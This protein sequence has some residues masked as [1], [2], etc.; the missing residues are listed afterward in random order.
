M[1]IIYKMAVIILFLNLYKVISIILFVIFV[2]ML[3]YI[4]YIN[5][6]YNKKKIF[7]DSILAKLHRIDKNFKKDEII[8]F[9]HKLEKTNISSLISKDHIF[10]NDIIDYIFENENNLKIFL[11]Y[12]KERSVA[13]NILKEGFKFSDS[14]YKT[15]E[16][17]YPDKISFV[18]K[19]NLRKHFGNYVIIIA[20]SKE[21]FDYYNDKLIVI[22]NSIL[23]VEHLLS[24]K[25]QGS[26]D[27]PEGFYLFPYQFIKGFINNETGEIIKNPGFN[28]EYKSEVFEQNLKNAIAHDNL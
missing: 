23:Y 22:S 1:I 7:L 2:V 17:I 6:L 18:Y 24:V 10:N 3:C 11:H 19:H 15:A 21:L 5:T 26:K 4:I 14:F 8:T 13:E 16:N 20:I 28:P 27:E 9:L 25:I 12:T